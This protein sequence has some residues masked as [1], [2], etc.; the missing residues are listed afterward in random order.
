MR[1]PPMN[2]TGSR[3]LACAS[4]VPAG[5]RMAVRTSNQLAGEKMLFLAFM[6]F[7][8]P[9]SLRLQALRI[10][11]GNTGSREQK[12]HLDIQFRR[13]RRRKHAQAE[14]S[15]QAKVPPFMEIVLRV[16]ETFCET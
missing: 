3:L 7:P 14:T 13:T 11:P 8:P 2:A 1:N 10:T 9:R 12:R 5:S 4:A 16:L 6:N 15:F